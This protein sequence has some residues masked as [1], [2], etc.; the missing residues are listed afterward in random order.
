[1]RKIDYIF[2]D[3][4]TQTPDFKSDRPAMSDLRHQL[5]ALGPYHYIVNSEGLIIPGLDLH[6][7]L[8]LIPGP[9][10][11]PDKYNRCSIFIRYC[12]SLRPESWLINSDFNCKAAQQQRVALLGLLCRLRKVFSDAKIL[13][14][15]E[16]NGKELHSR[17]IIVSDTMNLLRSELSNLP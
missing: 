13:G 16:L 5:S 12:G 7:T 10:Y 17:N 9:I 3:S 1:M 2:I 15:S 14:L 4:D 6:R 8:E 11:D